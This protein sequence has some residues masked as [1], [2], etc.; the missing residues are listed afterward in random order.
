MTALTL[1]WPHSRITGEEVVWSEL[2]ALC[3]SLFCDCRLLCRKPTFFQNTITVNP[4]QMLKQG[5]WVHPKQLAWITAQRTAFNCMAHIWKNDT[6]TCI[7]ILVQA[8]IAR[9]LQPGYALFY[10]HPDIGLWAQEVW[11]PVLPLGDEKRKELEIMP[12]AFI[13]INIID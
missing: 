2:P 11:R 6:C 5:S 8:S 12:K 7:R 4:D 10:W 3:F 1:F 13:T 9:A